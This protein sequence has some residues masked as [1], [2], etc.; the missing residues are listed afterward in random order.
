MLWKPS[1]SVSSLVDRLLAEA[2]D[3]CRL[4]IDLLVHSLLLGEIHPTVV[5]LDESRAEVRAN[6][7]VFRIAVIPDLS[8]IEWCL[9]RNGFFQYLLLRDDDLMRALSILSRVSHHQASVMSIGSYV[10]T[11]ALFHPEHG[12]KVAIAKKLVCLSGGRWSPLDTGDAVVIT[13]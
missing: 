4:A 6:D 2:D 1:E 9:E 13:A 3:P 8:D 12:L 7:A 11:Q 5:R 10:E